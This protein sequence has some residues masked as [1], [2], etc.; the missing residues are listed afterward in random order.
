VARGARAGLVEAGDGQAVDGDLE[1][2]LARRLVSRG[3]RAP[4]GAGHRAARVLAARALVRAEALLLPI[5]GAPAALIAVEEA[6]G[7]RGEPVDDHRAGSGVSRRR[8]EERHEDREEVRHVD[9]PTSGALR[10]SR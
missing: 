6:V 2:R 10:P 7:V 5:A 8:Q 9:V 3:L 4:A 1:A